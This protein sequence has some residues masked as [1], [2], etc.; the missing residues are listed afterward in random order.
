MSEAR[1][2]SSSS[3]LSAAPLRHFPLRLFVTYRRAAS[4]L[5]AAPLVIPP[6]RFVTYRR[7]EVSVAP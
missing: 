2:V 7:A 3:S 4:S 5:T 1:L 6:R